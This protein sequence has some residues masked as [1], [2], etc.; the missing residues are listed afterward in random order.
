MGQP[1]GVGYEGI[2]PKGSGPKYDLNIFKAPGGGDDRSL[3][4]RPRSIHPRVLWESAL[5]VRLAELKTHTVE[6]TLDADGYQVAVYGIPGPEFNQDPR[7]SSVRM[8]SRLYTCFHYP[9]KSP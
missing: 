5:P 6:P 1:K 4:S 7:C 8:D 3:R 2:D 9:R